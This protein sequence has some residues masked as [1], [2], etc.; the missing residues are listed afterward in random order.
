MAKSALLIGDKVDI[1]FENSPFYRTYVEDVESDGAILRVSAPME[2]ERI[3]PIPSSQEVTLY[4]YR[5]NG[6]FNI[7]TR[8][9]E[10]RKYQSGVSVML[11]VLSEPRKEQQREF[12]RLPVMLT[13]EARYLPDELMRSMPNALAKLYDINDYDDAVLAMFSASQYEPNVSVRDISISGLSIR[14]S[15]RYKPGD[16]VA[17]KIYLRWPRGT[18]MPLLAVTEVRRVQFHADTKKYF[19]GL[20]FFGAFSQRELI[21]KYIYEQQRLRIQQKRLVEGN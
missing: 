5:E 12:Y 4:F 20:E 6:K 9:K 1:H 3:V 15:R 18:N 19:V 11:E 16:H 14:C 13:A 7:T 17:V 2:K 10:F 21:T 8:V